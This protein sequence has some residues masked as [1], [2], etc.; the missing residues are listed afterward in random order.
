MS[1]TMFE[2]VENASTKISYT[3]SMEYGVD[4][5]TGRADLHCEG[6]RKIHQ[7]KK[8]MAKELDNHCLSIMGFQITT[9]INNLPTGLCNKIE[10]LDI[11][12]ELILWCN[13]P[14]F[15]PLK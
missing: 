2:Q 14:L 3:L 1:N 11:I 8:S 13:I 15:S 10:N 5:R 6:E 9:S 4:F 7:I 12:N